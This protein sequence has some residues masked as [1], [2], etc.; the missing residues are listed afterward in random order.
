MKTKLFLLISI[1]CLCVGKVI[2]QESIITELD[3]TLLDKY[4][5]LAMRNYPRKKA[6]DARLVRAKTTV[7]TAQLSWLDIFNANYYYSPT[8][9]SGSIGS[10][11]GGSQNTSGQI[12]TQGLMLGVS[13]N[14]GSLFSKPSLVKAAKADYEAAKAETDEYNITLTNEVK[15][16]YYTFLLARRQLQ[17]RS[18]ATQS[19]KSIMTE[20]RTKYEKAEIPI[21][22]YTTARNSSTEAESMALN[23]EV[24]Y[25]KAKNALEEIIGV[26]LEDV[27]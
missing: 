14:L 10:V 24:D 12:I 8:S 21:D 22:A 20:V 13:A 3:N 1:I 27:K 15:S 7:T 9:S 17:V 26:R 6:F 11:G 16:R 2:A 18:M 5:T 4:I 19:Y 25:L 23:A